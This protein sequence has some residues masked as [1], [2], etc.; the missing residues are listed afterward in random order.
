MSF[1]YMSVTVLCMYCL[2]FVIPVFQLRE[3]HTGMFIAQWSRRMHSL[4]P[5]CAW[6]L[7]SCCWLTNWAAAT[8]MV[9]Q[10]HHQVSWYLY[11]LNNSCRVALWHT[12][13]V[14][15]FTKL[16][17]LLAILQNGKCTFF[18]ASMTCFFMT[19]SGVLVP[20]GRTSMLLWLWLIKWHSSVRCFAFGFQRGNRPLVTKPTPLWLALSCMQQVQWSPLSL[21]FSLWACTMSSSHFRFPVCHFQV[22]IF[23]TVG[24][25][26]GCDFTAMWSSEA[27]NIGFYTSLLQ[28][29]PLNSNVNAWCRW[30]VPKQCLC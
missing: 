19:E 14:F 24:W 13:A 7:C 26:A 16:L 15:F 27:K 2:R 29:F 23:R 3:N 21:V 1:L 10:P 8:R 20:R 25:A 11:V 12:L 9:D 28:S 18:N 30:Y 17:Y 22:A 5:C 6:A 4:G